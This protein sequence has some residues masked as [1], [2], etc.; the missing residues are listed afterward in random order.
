MGGG[1][2]GFTYAPEER[3]RIED[4]LNRIDREPDRLQFLS[5]PIV[6]MLIFLALI[7]G[8]CEGLAQ[9]LVTFYDDRKRKARENAA[10]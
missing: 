3:N 8:S 6:I 7:K 1:D 5:I 4:D 9:I 10:R 2:M